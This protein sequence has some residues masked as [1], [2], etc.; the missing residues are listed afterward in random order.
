MFQVG[1]KVVYP[2][3]GAGIIEAIE[4]REVLGQKKKYYIMRFPLGDVKVMLPL[5]SEKAAGLREVVDEEGVQEVIKILKEKK[6]SGNTGNNWNHRY[7]ANLEKLRSGNICQV[8]E[9][10]SI[11][12][13]REHDKGLSTGERKMLE[14]ARQILISE[15]ILA[16][17]YEKKQV[18]AMLEKLLA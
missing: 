6:A 3:H 14:N 11:L 7:R 5:E 18:E 8:A 10:V 1:D 16:R 2:M 13:R 17:N 4:E 15:L 9:V 12:A